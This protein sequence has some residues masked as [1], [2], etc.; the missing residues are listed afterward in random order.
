MSSEADIIKLYDTVDLIFDWSRAEKFMRCPKEAYYAHEIGLV[1]EEKVSHHLDF[2]KRLHAHLETG[3]ESE[4]EG[5]KETKLYPKD[6]KVK[7]KGLDLVKMYHAKFHKDNARF[8]VIA[9][10]YAFGDIINYVSMLTSKKILIKGKIDQIVIDKETGLY[11]AKDYKTTGTYIDEETFFNSYYLGAQNTFYLEALAKEYG[12][13]KVGGFI[14][15]VFRV[16]R[17]DTDWSDIFRRR[18]EANEIVRYNYMHDIHQWLNNKDT[19]YWHKQPMSCKRYN[20]MCDFYNLCR[21]G[22]SETELGK[23][24]KRAK[25][26]FHR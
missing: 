12:A 22:E 5:F 14:V 24:K 9:N 1:S 23:F 25:D 8:G 20:R 18:I 11:Y 3:N 21:F 26:D 4:W 10:E 6:F 19:G 13:D 17:T 16:T 2:G 15:D 7:Q